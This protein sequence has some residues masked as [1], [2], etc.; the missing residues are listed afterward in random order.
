MIQ[1]NRFAAIDFETADYGKDSA[2][3]LAVV[4]VEKENIVA[5]HYSLIR[6]PRQYFQFTWLHNI[7]WEDVREEPSF[8]ELWPE[9]AP[10]FA[11]VDFIAAHNASF[12]RGV[13]T[14]CCEKSGFAPPALPYL[15]TMRLSRQLWDIYPTKLSDVCHRFSISLDHHHAESDA[16]ACAKIALRAWHSGIPPKAFLRHKS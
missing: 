9:I 16:T 5:T 8:G 7:S 10:L 3:A 11:D 15:C 14:A 1:F 13:L 4:I 2:C 6:P 12:D